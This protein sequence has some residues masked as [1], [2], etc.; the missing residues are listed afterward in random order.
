MLGM[1]Y[2]EFRLNI[3]S[4]LIIMGLSLVY[5]VL[6]TFMLSENGLLH[7]IYIDDIS[8]LIFIIP[9]MTTLFL[10]CAM[11]GSSFGGDERKKWAYFTTSLPCDYKTAIGAKY[12]SF[13]AVSQEMRVC[14]I[15]KEYRC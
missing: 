12:L 8:T 2:K 13:S 7:D 1:L 3:L 6:F 9:E 14:S 4:L 10:A 11:A 15:T 5:M